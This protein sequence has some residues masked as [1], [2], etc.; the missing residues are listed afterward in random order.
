MRAACALPAIA[1]NIPF[2]IGLRY[3]NWRGLQVS[4][5]FIYASGKHERILLACCLGEYIGQNAYCSLHGSQVA[6]VRYRK[7]VAGLQ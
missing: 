7:A 3:L 2:G 5:R 4:P 6:L 1:I